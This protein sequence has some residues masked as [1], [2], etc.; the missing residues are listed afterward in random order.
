MKTTRYLTLCLLAV[1]M[2]VLTSCYRR[3]LEVLLNERVNVR[4]TVNW[5]TT[6]MGDVTKEDSVIAAKYYGG[7]PNGMTLMLWGMNTG[8][9]FVESVNGNYIDVALK[10][11]TYRLIIFNDRE[12]EFLPYQRLYDKDSYDNMTMRLTHYIPSRAYWSNDYIYYPDPVGVA[13]DTFQI[14]DEMVDRDSL[15]FAPYEDY[16]KGGVL[17]NTTLD[18]RSYEILEKA[19]P[20]TVTLYM[21]CKVK[22]RESLQGIEASISGMSDGFYLS[23]VN[24][25]QETGAIELNSKA[26]EYYAVGDPNEALGVI[27]NKTATFGLPYGKEL[28][29]ERNAADNILS[30]RITLTNGDVQEY[31]F[32]VGKNIRYITPEGREAQIRY[33]EDLHDLQLEIDLQD[34]IVLPPLPSRGAG[35]DA[36]VA[37]W[38]EGGTFDVGGF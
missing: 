30:L 27:T 18:S 26:W 24:R 6:V 14:T 21:K 23:R 37:E 29:S 4:I 7:T 33:R 16:V 38:E 15:I 22:N 35:F 34:V 10:P 20:M 13:V 1:V 9:R 12:D 11:D 5:L 19:T 3:P 32:E 28:L 17:Q 8:E 2:T 36:R 25:T 31:S